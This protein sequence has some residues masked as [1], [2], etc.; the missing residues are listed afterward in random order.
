MLYHTQK[1]SKKAAFAQLHST[2][3]SVAAKAKTLPQVAV[4]QA[5]QTNFLLIVLSL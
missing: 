1:H 5:L 3:L 4:L 2:P